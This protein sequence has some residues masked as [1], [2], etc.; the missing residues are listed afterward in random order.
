MATNPL[1]DELL[2][3]NSLCF[4]YG[5]FKSTA[6]S[7]SRDIQELKERSGAAA[8]SEPPTAATQEFFKELNR[9]LVQLDNARADMMNVALRLES[10]AEENKVTVPELAA[11]AGAH[12]V[13]S[14]FETDFDGWPEEVRES[15]RDKVKKNPTFSQTMV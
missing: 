13:A 9:L 2:A 8:K 12:D 10:A 5:L 4:Q 15:I 11:M 3:V 1:S 6:S 14:T 7:I